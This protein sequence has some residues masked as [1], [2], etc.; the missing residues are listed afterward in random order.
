MSEDM[1]AA[2]LT[3]TAGKTGGIQFP[4]HFTIAGEDPYDHIEWDHRTALITSNTGEAVFEQEDVRTPAAWSQQAVNIVASMY[5]RGKPHTPE[6]ESDIAKLIDRVVNQITEW[7][8]AGRYFR[9][10]EDRDAFRDELKHIIV[11]QKASFN[12]PVWFNCGYRDNPQCSACFIISVEDSMESILELAKT[13]GM[14][15]KHGSG[16]GSNLSA[17]RGSG[18]M[19]NGGG[20]ASGPVSFMKGFD[21]FAGVI[22]SGG[23]CLMGGQPV[24]TTK[25]PVRITELAKRDEGFTCMSWDPPSGEFKEKRARAWRSGEKTVLRVTTDGGEFDVSSDHPF[26]LE[27]GTTLR[28]ENLPEGARLHTYRTANGGTPGPMTVTEVN[29][30]GYM[31]VYSV[32]VD[33]PT[34][35]DKSPSSGHT[36]VIWPDTAREG[37]GVVVHNTRRAA[38][39]VILNA[40]H[41]DIL[42]FIDCKAREEKKAWALIDAGYDSSITGDAYAS[43]FFQNANNSVRVTD[44]FMKA[45]A[46]DDPWETVSVT[47]DER[48]VGTHRARDLMRRIAEAAHVCGD[49]GMQF[50]TTVNAWHTCPKTDRIR[51]SNPCFVGDTEVLTS[52]GRI[53]IE[54]LA[55]MSA[56]GQQL[57]LA[58]THDPER[59]TPVLRQITRAW[60]SKTTSKLV[61]VQTDKGITVRCT[62]EHVFY[63]YDGRGMAASDLQHGQS[64]RKIGIHRHSTGRLAIASGGTREL[65]SRWL[66]T[67][68]HGAIPQENHIHHRNGIIDDDRLSNLESLPARDHW[69]GHAAGSRNARA[70]DVPDQTLLAVWK[71]VKAARPGWPVTVARWNLFVKR[72]GLEGQVPLANPQRGVRGM[73]WTEFETWIA[74]LQHNMP[75]VQPLPRKKA[76]YETAVGASAQQLLA[77][78][79]ELEK[80]TAVTWGR[81]NYHV[82]TR[83]LSGKIPQFAKAN[84]AAFAQRMEEERSLANDRVASVREITGEPVPVFDLEVEGVHRFA[85]SSDDALHGLVVS[86]CSEYMFL[87]DSAC[88]LAS[89]NLMKFEDPERGFDT[90]AFTAA[91]RTVITAQEI[92]VGNAGYPTP[93]IER[94]SRD[95]R[96]LGLGYCNLGAFLMSQAL[97][98][99]SDEGRAASAAITALM[100]GAAY[101]QS[102]AIA[103][104]AGG[105]FAGFEKNREPFL[106]VMDKHADAVRL[107]D[108]GGHP[109]SAMIAE[110]AD[111]AWREARADGRE[112]GFR[113]AQAT[114]L[115]PTGTIGFMMDCDTT[116]V[117]P[118]IALVKYKKL[119]NQGLMK[120]VNQ[121]VPKALARLGYDGPTADAILEHIESRDTIEGAPGLADEHLAVFDC[122]FK[123]KNGERSITPDGHIRMIGAV[124]PFIS[125]AISKTINMPTDTTVEDIERAYIDAWK[126]GA[127]SVSIYRDG[128]KR[129]Q[130]LTTGN[131]TAK[132][133]TA[134]VGEPV[135]RRLPDERRSMTH[136][137]EVGGHEGYVTVGMFEDG[138]PGEIFIVMAKEGSTISGFADA[139]AQAISYALQY[140]VPLE[141]LVNKFCHQ[142]FEPAGMTRNPKIRMAKSIVDYIVRWMATKFLDEEAQ[143]AVGINLPEKPEATKD[144][145]PAGDASRNSPAPGPAIGAEHPMAMNAASLVP[146]DQDAP[147]CPNCGG[148]MLRNG[149]CYACP[150]CGTT[151]GCS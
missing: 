103:R 47:D 139:F 113:N 37:A 71:G 30:L 104:D 126:L 28:A 133:G 99:N 83:G 3:D 147:P 41:P 42:D 61:E 1:K 150:N 141:M 95:Y 106:K 53:T 124:Q 143:R 114:V 93:A 109:L 8:D 125:G 149:T 9:T 17:L 51:A 36:F 7:G 151:S 90:E 76:L 64:L 122:A 62:P 59:R 128:S 44:A 25:G 100:T 55:E 105:P 85:V 39:M 58:I 75:D 82:K 84:W 15:F 67:Q 26:R 78:W 116:G 6:R 52:E 14:L 72:Q 4:R 74:K 135:R 65:F 60:Q 138:K 81:W 123:A 127:K 5:F 34:A 63:L 29:L 31:P 120:L 24:Y 119:V 45:V 10:A 77:V 110:A 79:E 2:D 118:D 146:N 111:Q 98:Y 27:D 131:D 129:T 132:A 68:Q 87:D 88:N 142:R 13:E 101:R 102:A 117:E 35:D 57:P 73:S 137:F 18:E 22:K 38:K 115:A 112:H 11:H 70:L 19:L 107:I 91:V 69:S 43:I 96:P 33:C 140:G 48:V 54:R 136:K 94:N 56:A 148:I 97:P 40:D 32:E 121:T 92:I 134:K 46:D 50:D 20:T 66:W 144:G 23:S 49:P 145:A 16:T 89:I 86:N 108:T 21:A 130:P 80:K 12:S